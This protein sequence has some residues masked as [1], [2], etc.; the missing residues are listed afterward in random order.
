[1]SK[2]MKK[3]HVTYTCDRCKTSFRKKY[4]YTC[5]LNRKTKCE[6]R[7]KAKAIIKPHVCKGCDKG[8]SRI[9]SLTRHHKKCK[10]YKIYLK[11]GKN[12]ANN[13]VIGV[14]VGTANVTINNITAINVD[15]DTTFFFPF[16]KCYDISHLNSSE[17]RLIMNHEVNP[18]L[19][20]FKC[21]FCNPSRPQFNNIY[22]PPDYDNH[23][24][25]YTGASWQKR[26]IGQVLNEIILLI[27]SQIV[28]FINETAYSL[29]KKTKDWLGSYIYGIYGSDIMSEEDLDTYNLKVHELHIEMRRALVKNEPFIGNHYKKYLDALNSSNEESMNSD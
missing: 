26:K 9:D 19:F 4:N 5:H 29:R 2:T 8:K 25:V 7:T 3:K 16:G 10:P 6:K 12:V 18:I 23:I 20:L 13:N 1:M 14:N 11:G 28:N 21:F 17:S 15:Y 22:Y 24:M 27:R